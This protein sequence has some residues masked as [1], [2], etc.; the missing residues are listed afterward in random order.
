MRG[1]PFLRV[2]EAENE[3]IWDC[4]LCEAPFQV[5]LGEVAIVCPLLYV[6]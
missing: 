6:L 2:S 3:P 1:P 5:R 4:L